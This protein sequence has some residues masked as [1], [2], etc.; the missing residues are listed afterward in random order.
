MP[1]TAPGILRNAKAHSSAL[2]T[3]QTLALASALAGAHHTPPTPPG[4]PNDWLQVWS[5]EFDGPA[6]ASVD[7]TKWRH[8]V[9]DGCAQGI[10]GWGNDEKEYYTDLTANIALNGQGQLTIAARL[11]PA[12]LT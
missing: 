2:A 7:G 11:A 10:C 1:Q 5:D 8:D 12:G 3:L 9:G 6:G 4:L